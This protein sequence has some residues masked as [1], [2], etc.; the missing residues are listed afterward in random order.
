MRVQRNRTQQPTRTV[1]I[2]FLAN[3]LLTWGIAPEQR[4]LFLQEGLADWE[5]MS[6]DESPPRMILRALRG[7][8]AAVAARMEAR[9]P[10]TIPVGLSV[11]SV[12]AAGMAAAI[13]ETTY[14]N[15]LRLFTFMA[16][17]GLLGMG[18]LLLRAPLRIE[19]RRQRGPAAVAGGGFM[20]MGFNIPSSDAWVYETP[21]IE[22]PLLDQAMASGFVVVGAGLLLLALASWSRRRRRAVL[23]AG[24]AIVAGTATYGIAQIIWAILAAPVDLTITLPSMFVGLAA[25]SVL[26]VMPRLRHLQIV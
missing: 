13:I 15:T 2:A 26:H 22:T 18:M 9:E 16:A 12:S 10:T 20:G 24:V 1:R 23:A 6:E 21:V 4:Q 11:A 8:P 25:L 19:T 7:F 17:V 3:R 14:P 5:A